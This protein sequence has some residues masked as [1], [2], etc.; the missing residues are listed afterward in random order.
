ME[1]LLEEPF[2]KLWN[3]L[4]INP[5]SAVLNVLRMIRTFL[6]FSLGMA[7]FRSPSVGHALGM[8]RQGFGRHNAEVVGIFRGFLN[9]F[10]SDGVRALKAT[11]SFGLA[12][13]DIFVLV[14]SLLILLLVDIAKSRTDVRAYIAARPVVLRFIIWFALLFYVIILGQY[15]PG[16]S[17]AEF[18]YQGF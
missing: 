15:G 13:V 4:K 9:A 6:L 17:A 1:E 7:F 10:S 5:D 16:Y 12:Y 8:L 14:F 18:I 11:S 2:K 3:S